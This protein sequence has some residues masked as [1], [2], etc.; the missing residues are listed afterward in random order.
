M[1]TCI[2]AIP[3]QKAYIYSPKD[4]YESVPNSAIS[5]NPKLK[6]AHQ[7]FIKSRNRPLYTHTCA[8]THTDTIK[9]YN[10]KK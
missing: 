8:R 9:Y 5:N 4:V 6:S 2:P 7:M 3:L 1:N 10:A